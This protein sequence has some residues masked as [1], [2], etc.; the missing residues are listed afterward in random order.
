[1]EKKKYI[2]KDENLKI[3]KSAD[4][5]E[6]AEHIFD[7][8]E[9]A[10]MCLNNIQDNTDL[11]MKIFNLKKES[12]SDEDEID[13]LQ[14]V[15]EDCIAIESQASAVMENIAIIKGKIDKHIKVSEGQV[16]Q[17][18]KEILILELHSKDIVEKMIKN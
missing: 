4:G 7:M 5:T 17:K 2:L 13:A 16:E 18:L 9:R 11:C 6:N 12:L 8:I 14:L 10:E 3:E 1:M 15:C